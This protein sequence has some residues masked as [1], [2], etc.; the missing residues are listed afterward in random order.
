MKARLCKSALTV[1]VAIAITRSAMGNLVT[2]G[3]FTTVTYNGTMPS[4]LNASTLF[5]QF[6]DDSQ[7][8]KATGSHLTVAGWNTSGY[9]YV[10]LPST[11]SSGTVASGANSGQPHEAPGESDALVGGY[12]NTYMWGATQGGVAGTGNGGKDV[13]T[14]PP[15]GSNIIAAD[16]AYEV[17]AITQT[18]TGLTVGQTYALTFYYGAAQQQSYT[19]QTTESWTVAFGS[20]SQTTST[21]TLGSEDFSGWFQATMYFTAGSTSQV[22]SF[23]ANGTPSGE[24]PFSLL[25]DVDLEVV[26]EFSNWLTFAGF[27]A[28]CIFFE[29]SRRRRRR[30]EFGMNAA[31]VC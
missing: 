15:G 18:V 19:G 26:P 16:G 13:I 9:N 30:G 25:A 22:L 24:P 14:A 8:G 12:G 20:S 5:G 28:G 23:T 31:P 2:D 10:F 1:A 21:I 6:G 3:T 17:G 7:T 11:I 29:V 27:G 4:G